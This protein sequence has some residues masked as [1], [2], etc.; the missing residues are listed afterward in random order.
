MTFL[1]AAVLGIIEGLTEFLPVS[2]TGHLILTSHLLGVGESE[3]AKAFEVIIQSGA[4]VA[5]IWEYRK[6]LGQTCKGIARR[7]PASLHLMNLILLAFLPAAVLGVLCSKYIKA[8][9]FGIGPVAYALIVGG[10]VMIIVERWMKNSRAAH[11]VGPH[12]EKIS[13]QNALV[14]GFAQCFSLWPGTSRSMATILGGRFVGLNP[15]QAAEFSFL[16]AI[17]TIVG[18]SVYDL[19]KNRAEIAAADLSFVSLFI[20]LVFSFA[21]ALIVIRVFLKFLMSHSLEIFGWYRILVGLA[22]LLFV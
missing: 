3:A 22:F 1:D 19:Y 10:I 6:L 9:L 12:F 16:L 15:R 14:I 18:A 20:G 2:S 4:I 5:V 11:S 7:N 13:K 8:Y 21:T 17:P